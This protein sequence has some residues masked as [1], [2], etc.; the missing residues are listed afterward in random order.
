MGKLT[1]YRIVFYKSEYDSIF[2]SG[3]VSYI[4]VVLSQQ[5]AES[6]KLL[7]LG[8]NLTMKHGFLLITKIKL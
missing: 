1:I 5:S 4:K 8:F 6:Q 2:D 7:V 3:H